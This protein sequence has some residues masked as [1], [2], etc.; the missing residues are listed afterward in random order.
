MACV[1]LPAICYIGWNSQLPSL[2]QA[3]S[4]SARFP[5]ALESSRLLNTNVFIFMLL[6]HSQEEPWL[7]FQLVSPHCPNPSS[8]AAGNRNH[9]GFYTAHC[10]CASSFSVILLIPVFICHPSGSLCCCCDWLHKWS[11]LQK[12]TFKW[13]PQVT[14]TSDCS[15]D[16]GTRYLMTQKSNFWCHLITYPSPGMESWWALPHK[17]FQNHLSGWEA[18]G[19]SLKRELLCDIQHF[20]SNFSGAVSHPAYSLC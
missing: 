11:S 7:W 15:E 18:L 10:W 13:A 19:G 6:P 9:S 20:A 17:S 16:P 1:S 3:S 8:G 5:A 4:A 14:F 12:M 2:V